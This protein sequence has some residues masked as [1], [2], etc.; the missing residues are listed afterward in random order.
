HA[1]VHEPRAGGNEPARRG[2]PRRRVRAGRAPV[3]VADG[4]HALRE[5]AADQGELRRDSPN[6]PRGGA[7]AAEQAAEQSLAYRCRLRTESYVE[8]SRKSYRR[9]QRLEAV[10][11]SGPE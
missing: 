9:S 2:H 5:G 8:D 6:C 10:A 11:P 3:R 4:D 1:L 7:A